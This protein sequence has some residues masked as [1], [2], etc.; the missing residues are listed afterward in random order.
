[1]PSIFRKIYETVK[2]F[3]L[4]IYTDFIPQLPM[5]SGIEVVSRLPFVASRNMVNM[6]ANSAKRKQDENFAIV[7]SKRQR[8]NELA[9]RNDQQSLMQKVSVLFLLKMGTAASKMH[10]CS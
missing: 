4:I 7:P 10:F 1:M 8:Q 9:I 5:L 6:D 2:Q 3:M